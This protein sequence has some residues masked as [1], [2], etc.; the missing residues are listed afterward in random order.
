MTE[1]QVTIYALCDPDTNEVRYIGQT[2]N[3]AMRLQGHMADAS[4]YVHNGL[5]IYAATCLTSIID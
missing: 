1:R 5:V 2:V 3:M 4:G